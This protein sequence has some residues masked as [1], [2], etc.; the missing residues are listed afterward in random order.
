M[1]VCLVCLICCIVFCALFVPYSIKSASSSSAGGRKPV[2]IFPLGNDIEFV[3]REVIKPAISFYGDIRIIA[4]DFNASRE[5]I[6]VFERLMGE[7]HN[8]E[9]IKIK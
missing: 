8:Y 9:I 1:E 4:A 2:L 5:N 3:Y 6:S 7:Y